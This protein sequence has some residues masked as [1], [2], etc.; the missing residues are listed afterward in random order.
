MTFEK[1][2]SRSIIVRHPDG[3]CFLSATERDFKANE[4]NARTAVEFIA[5]MHDRGLELRRL[6]SRSRAPTHCHDD[7]T[8]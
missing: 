3:H 8:T 2:G 5:R 6:R 7:Q 1:L 4:T